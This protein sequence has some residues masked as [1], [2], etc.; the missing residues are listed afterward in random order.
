MKTFHG[1]RGPDSEDALGLR[2]LATG[3]GAEGRARG[4]T[5]GHS[6]HGPGVGSPPS[7]NWGSPN[8]ASFLMPTAGYNS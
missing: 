3:C 5:V 6:L 4:V 8:Q 1:E 7:G 2:V